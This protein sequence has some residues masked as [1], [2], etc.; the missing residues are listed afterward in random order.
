VTD[1]K[2]MEGYCSTGQSPQWA[3]VPVEE[4]LLLLTQMVYVFVSHA[5]ARR[6]AV[7]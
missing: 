6:G 5:G 2:E 3:V 7:C 4:V 1:R